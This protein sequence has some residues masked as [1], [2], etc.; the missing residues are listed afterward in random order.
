MANGQPGQRLH[1]DTLEPC[2]V[3]PICPVC[4]GRMETVYNRPTSKVCVCVVC[5]SGITIP[6]EAWELALKRIAGS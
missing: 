1:P 4:G 3:V 5:H 6:A 2:E